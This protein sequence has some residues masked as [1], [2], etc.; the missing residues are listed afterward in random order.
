M[1]PRKQ[2][3]VAVDR[4]TWEV[5]QTWADQEFRSINSQI[6]WLV[7]KHLP[8]NLRKINKRPNFNKQPNIDKQ[9]AQPVEIELNPWTTSPVKIRSRRLSRK[10][11]LFLVINSLSEMNEPLTN[12]ELSNLIPELT[13]KQINK[14]TSYA[15]ESGLLTRQATGHSQPGK[16]L[17]QLTKAGKRHINRA[18]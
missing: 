4:E 9:P 2:K 7:N 3:S 1:D 6:S 16:F 18:V 10:S 17:F 8:T 11:Q 13:Q 12:F 15:F 5:L 14:R